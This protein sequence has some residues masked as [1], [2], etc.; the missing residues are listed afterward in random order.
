MASFTYFSKAECLPKP[1]KKIL[2]DIY[3]QSFSISI[4]LNKTRQISA[5]NWEN[6]FII[7]LFIISL[8][9]PMMEICVNRVYAA[10]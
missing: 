5:N 9:V 1:Q 8:W 7:Y 4:S 3:L 6:L 2:Y 10:V